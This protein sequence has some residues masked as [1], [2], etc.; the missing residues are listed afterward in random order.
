MTSRARQSSL[1]RPIA[2]RVARSSHRPTM[3]ATFHPSESSTTP[4]PPRRIRSRRRALSSSGLSSIDHG[5]NARSLLSIQFP[6]SRADSFEIARAKG[7]LSS[8]SFFL[9]SLLSLSLFSSSTRLAKLSWYLERLALD[10]YR[11]V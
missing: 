7:G 6:W 10:A 1:K 4:P 8:F 5:C 2:N 3:L 9:S 11:S